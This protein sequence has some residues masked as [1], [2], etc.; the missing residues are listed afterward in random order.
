LIASWNLILVS[1]IAAS[2]P[3]REVIPPLPLVVAVIP[4]AAWASD[5]VS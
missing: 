2:R 5:S 3:S 1:M 4:G